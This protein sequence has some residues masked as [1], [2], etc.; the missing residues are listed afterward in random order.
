MRIGVGLSSTIPGCSGRASRSTGRGAPTLDPSRQL[1]DARPPCLRLP[2]IPSPRSPPPPPSRRASAS[3]PISPSARCATRR[4]SPSWPPRWT[5]SPA[6]ASR[7]ASPSARARRTTRPRAS[8]YASARTRALSS[9]WSDLR[10]VWEERAI[11]PRHGARARRSCCSAAHRAAGLCAR[12]A[13]RRWLRAWRRPAARL[14]PRR[15]K[16]ARRL[17]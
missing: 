5:R 3:P 2:T 13:L 15:R 12:R 7:W 4:C 11:G 9:S 6:G 1:A 16:S 10:D 17:G 14:R 8:S